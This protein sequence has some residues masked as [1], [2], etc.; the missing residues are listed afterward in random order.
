MTGELTLRRLAIEDE[1]QVLAAVDEFE[2]DGSHWS[3]R[4]RPE[5][6]WADYVEL[7][8]GWED[9][10][11]LPDGFVE[12]AEL[13]AVVDEEIVGRTSIRFLLNEFLREIGGH[14]GYAVRPGFRR[15]GYATEILRQSLDIAHEHGI[16]P[17]LVTCDVDN[18]GSR[19]VI[20]A[21]GGVLEG[22]F[23]AEP[24]MPQKRRYWIT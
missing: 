20:E 4:Y 24:G 18:V 6:P 5:L 11:D 15:R 12:H 2:A 22:I 8:H 17:V 7:V 10:I 21:N 9:G 14:I 3:Y 23:D 16:S 19:S 1:Q 13:V